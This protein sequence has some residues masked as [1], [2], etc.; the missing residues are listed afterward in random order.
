L[1]PQKAERLG[2]H[3]I[4]QDRLLPPSFTVG[5]PLFLGREPRLRAFSPVIDRRA[6][7]RQAAGMAA[8][9]QAEFG[10]TVAVSASLGSGAAIGAVNAFSVVS[11]RILPLLATLAVMNIAAGLELVITQN[12]VIAADTGFLSL[13]SSNGVGGVPSS[14]SCSR[15]PPF[16]SWPCNIRQ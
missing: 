12:T 11:L 5:E 9:I 13:L 1:T 7:R 2:I 8:L 10:D 6:M 3:F 14:R 4:H 15:S 16:L